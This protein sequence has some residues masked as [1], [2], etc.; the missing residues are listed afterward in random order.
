MRPTQKPKTAPQG[1]ALIVTLTLMVL[2][3]ILAIGLLTLS[4]VSLRASGAGSDQA[5]ARSNA[6][7]ALMLAIGDLQKHAG[8]DTRITAKADMLDEKNPQVMGVWRSWEGTDHEQSGA[9]QGRP[10]SPGNYATKKKE[11]F[12]AWLVSGD[13]ATM[14]DTTK[15][16]DKVTLLGQNSV[17]GGSE[18]EK[19]QVHLTPTNVKSANQQGSFA[20]WVSGENQKARL[21]KPYEPTAD[22]SARWSMNAKSHAVA[23]PKPFNLDSLLTDPSLADKS[24]TLKEVDLVSTGGDMK[25]SQAFFHDLSTSS[26]GLLT[27]VATGGWKKDLSLLTENWDRVGTSGL[28]L[29]RVSPG[30]DI[31]ATLPTQGDPCP[32]KSMLYPWA[33]YRG[34]ST[35]IPIYRHG[36]VTSWE[37]LKDYALAYRNKGMSFSSNGQA[38][39]PTSSVAIDDTA[40]SFGFLHKVRVL[41]LIARIQWVFSHS[42]TAVATPPGS[43]QAQ[44][45]LTPVITMW[46]PYNAELTF[47]SVPLS[48]SIPRPL[49]AALKY[50]I[51]GVQN[52]EFNSLTTGSLNYPTPLGAAPTAAAALGYR[53]SQAF[54]LKPGETRVFSPINQAAAGTV[55]ELQPGYRNNV[56]HFFNLKNSTGAAAIAPSSASI[57]ADA[58]LDT[59]Y[60]DGNPGVGIYL[61]MSY[62]GRRH[63]AYRMVYTPAVAAS[64]YPPISGLGSTTLG[65]ASAS[66]FPFMTTIFGA[67]MASKTHIAAKGFVQSSPLVNYTAMGGKD[68]IESTISRHYGGTNH[69]VNSPFDYSSVK[70]SPFSSDL[71]NVSD[72]TNRG[73]IVTGFNKS[74]GLSRCVIDE[75]PTRPLSSLGELTNW[76]LRYENPI[77]PF[78]FNLIGNSDASPLIGAGSVVG[79]YSD[80]V[81]LQHDD[82]YCA[83]HLLFDDWIFSSIAPDP[84]TFGAGGKSLQKTFTDF[85]SGVS[86]LG[87]NAYRP[88][89]QDAALAAASVANANTLFNNHVAKTDS[90]RSIASRL[91][92]EGLFN[93]NSTS[94]K[95]WR[96]LIGHARNQ[97][98]PFIK[99]TGNAWSVEVSDKSDYAFS[100]FSIAGDAEAKTRAVATFP[101]ATEFSGY[102]ILDEEMLD[103]LATQ[104][105]RQVRQR[106]PFLSLSEFINRQLSS[107][108]LALAGTIQAALDEIAKTTRTNPY[109]NILSV[110]NRPSA[111]SPAS[112]GDAEY[113]FPNAAVGQTS[114]G[115][116]GWTRQA[117]ILRPLAPILTARDDTFTIR[118]YGDARDKT[119]RITARATCEA[120]VRRIRDYVDPTDLAEITTLPTR[121]VNV[122]FGRRFQLVSMRWL[123]PSEI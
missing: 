107:G 86:P 123:N 92:V 12:L 65:A 84:T 111:A 88:L 90:W 8:N 64:V 28:P 56:G 29:F 67:R 27:N 70:V 26:V 98:V 61:D 53:V 33:G 18:R 120:V 47:S 94:V 51:N 82:S 104:I 122:S 78:A 85:V 49:P 110:N 3:T 41:P 22:N 83:N 40:D 62:N 93:V 30:Q 114:Y 31:Q 101:E 54:T 116:P 87:N 48:F 99:D 46:N 74:D 55:L 42:A 106:G 71:P 89:T 23:D 32:D 5:L 2:L 69:P 79:T 103:A 34:S 121:P 50:S 81:N 66:P 14:P 38:T 108:N 19:L 73:Y 75:L 35:N 115:L 113:Q 24:I 6:R 80:A 118:A 57:S 77:P 102:R 76:D 97:K 45:L 25:A 10:V 4:S 59:S 91:E 7:L 100:R 95:A 105:V 117:D 63:L 96:A 68:T 37:N 16:G 17:G 36:A 43:F 20:W 13:T 52:P 1:F 11:R 9:F 44:L 21:P 109:S 58:V 39:I 112:A 72:T 60:L 15:A 119:G